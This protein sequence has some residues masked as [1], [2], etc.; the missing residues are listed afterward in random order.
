MSYSDIRFPLH[1]VVLYIL[2]LQNSYQWD[3]Q[4]SPVPVC[5]SFTVKFTIIK[6]SF[7][8]ALANLCFYIIERYRRNTCAK[9]SAKTMWYIVPESSFKLVTRISL[10]DCSSKSACFTFS[11]NFSLVAI[12]TESRYL[13]WL[14]YYLGKQNFTKIKDDVPLLCNKLPCSL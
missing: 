7:L 14:L 11:I 12:L 5:C 3:K 4:H 1:H 10:V 8:S 6:L 2:P 13:H 9:S